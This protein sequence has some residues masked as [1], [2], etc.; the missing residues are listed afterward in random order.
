MT[1]VSAKL[2]RQPRVHA[3]NSSIQIVSSKHIF[4]DNQ[5]F[6]N[7]PGKM[8]PTPSTSHVNFEHI[9]EPAEDSYLL[10]DTLSSRAESQFLHDRFPEHSMPPPFVLEVGTGSGVV[11]AFVTAH[12]QTI[13]GRRDVVTFGTDVNRFACHATAKTADIAVANANNPVADG[14]SLPTAATFLNS[15]TADLA[16]CIKPGSVDVLICNPPYVPSDS[17][18]TIQSVDWTASGSLASS[19]QFERDSYLLSLS[20]AGGHDGMEMTNRLLE[21]LPNVLS[22][23]GVA[24]LLLCAQN[25]PDATAA[26][27]RAWSDRWRVETIST[28]GKQAGWE[29]LCVLRIWRER[30]P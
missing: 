19:A 17:S 7:F 25:K 26:R 6:P 20:Y 11:L 28:S 15:V 23:R 2:L 4:I 5:R 30:V 1:W 21:G 27:I 14:S 10:L 13:F 18:P 12:A 8:L 16:N 3:Q 9:Y 22:S 24:Y 29:R